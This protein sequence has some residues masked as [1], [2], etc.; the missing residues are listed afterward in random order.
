M[1]RFRVLA[2]L[3]AACA[4]GMHAQATTAQDEADAKFLRDLIETRSFSLGKPVGARFL[5][6]G[7]QVLFLR[8]A[9]SRKPDLGFYVFDVANGKTR[10]LLTPDQVLKGAAEKLSP[11][12]KARRE[13]MRMNQVKGFAGFAL[14]D[15]Q[16]HVLLALSGRVYVAAIDGRGAVEV[17]GPDDKGNAPF[18][19]RFSPDGRQVSFVRAGEL[20]VV[21]AAGGKARQL[22]RGAGG[23]I[24]HAQAEFVA[25][26]EMNRFTGY[27]WSPDAKQLAYQVSDNSKVEALYLADPLDPFGAVEPAPYPRPGTANVDVRLAVMPFA[28]GKATFIE[29]DRARYPYLAHVVWQEGGP[30]T[31]IVETRDQKDLSLLVADPKTGTSHELVHE[32]D[33]AWVNLGFEYTWLED[34]SGFLWASERGGWWQLELHAPDGKLVR[35]L[36]TPELGFRNAV[37]IDLP[38]GKLVVAAGSEPVDGGLYE[39]ALADGKTTMISDPKVVTNARYARKSS[40]HILYRADDTRTYPDVVV[41]ADGQSAGELSDLSEKPPLTAKPVVRKVGDGVGF[42]SATV[43]PQSFDPTH[44]YPV[45]VYV[46]GGP[47]GAVVNRD[48]DAYMMDQWIADHGYIVVKLDNR[49]TPGRGRDWER[50]IFGKFADVPLDDQ[51]AGLLALGKL[52]PAMDLTRVGIWGHSFGGFMSALAVMRRPDVYKAGIAGAPVA[53]WLDYDTCYTERYLGVP[54]RAKDTPLYD[55]N[56]LLL[57]AKDL[58]RPLLIIHGTADDNVHLSH[59]LRLADALLLAG[60]E[61]EFLPLAGET[62]G[63]RDPER[64]LRYYQRQFAFFRKNL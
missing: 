23:H 35:A 48:M 1:K 47:G 14:S 12:E 45:L 13:R 49:G 43:R 2:F 42:W 30:L 39:V 5:D 20:W 22:T 57:Y 52:E 37:H 11:Q 17:A 10:E 33:D 62:H 21:P 34:G 55:A 26:E 60:K 54:D 50:A 4:G 8:S 7:S 36:T 38:A 15:D 31:F 40:A 18:D 63:P 56:G 28:G 44:R 41:R 19:Q 58:T 59:S 53:D 29:W 9:G 6:D 32:H 24:E 64:L 25:Q 46:Y 3:L 51:V 61:F 27:W 16:N